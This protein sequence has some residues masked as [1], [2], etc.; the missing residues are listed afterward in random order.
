MAGVELNLAFAQTVAESLGSGKDNTAL[1]L[2][3]PHL[4]IAAMTGAPETIG[5]RLEVDG[6]ELT[7][8]EQGQS[9]RRFHDAELDSLVPVPVG[10]SGVPW[11]LRIRIPEVHITAA[12]NSLLVRQVAL[13]AL[14]ALAALIL[15]WFVGGGVAR[16]SDARPSC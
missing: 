16:P 12:A 7:A 2:L 11:T 1:A 10:G 5:T 13:G 8:L 4:M 3:T 14:C 9:P 6:A 15:L